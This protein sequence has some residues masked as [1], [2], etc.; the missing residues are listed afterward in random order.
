MEGTHSLRPSQISTSLA[1]VAG[2]GDASSR[3]QMLPHSCIL[4]PAVWHVSL[5]SFTRVVTV[6]SL[7]LPLSVFFQF[8]FHPFDESHEET[9]KASICRRSQ[10]SAC[11][12]PNGALA[13]ACG[14]G[15]NPSQSACLASAMPQRCL[16]DASAILRPDWLRFFYVLLKHRANMPDASFSGA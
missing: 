9:I 16:S 8:F 11:D 12:L 14:P 13:P 2:E 6:V 15:A 1:C 10:A 5:V 7:I 4:H 3:R